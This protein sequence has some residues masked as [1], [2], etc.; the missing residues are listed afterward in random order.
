MDDPEHDRGEDLQRPEHPLAACAEQGQRD[1][2]QD[3]DEQDLQDLPGGEGA[4]EGVGNDGEKEPGHRLLVRLADI[5]RHRPLIERRRIDV[6]PSARADDVGD[7]E[8]DRQ[9]QRREGQE[10]GHSLRAHPPERL[11]I[12]HSGDAGSDGEEDDRS[13]DRLDQPDERVPQRLQRGSESGEEPADENAQR[14]RDEHP[15]VEAAPEGPFP[16]HVLLPPLPPPAATLLPLASTLS[17]A[18]GT[19]TVSPRGNPAPQKGDSYRNWPLLAGG[20]RGLLR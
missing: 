20:A 3:R 7:D 1:P 11:E 10:I 18:T 15:E 6:Q 13:D 5:G 14:D 2:E 19:V 8:P 9:R 17:Q 16:N 12:R 4:E